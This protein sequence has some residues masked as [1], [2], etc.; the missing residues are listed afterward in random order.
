MYKLLVSLLV[1]S[2][3]LFAQSIESYVYGKNQ[4][5]YFT[6][7][8]GWVADNQAG[9]DFDFP[10]VLYPKDSSWDNATTVI[11][12]TSILK[13]KHAKKPS[14]IVRNVLKRF[15]TEL[16][17]PN[18][19]AVKVSSVN[20]NSGISAPIYKYTGDRNGNTEYVSYF[21]ADKTVNIFVMTSQD[22]NDIENSK[23]AF[24]VLNKSYREAKDC[25]P[26]N[27]KKQSCSKK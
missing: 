2:T 27:Q 19:K 20:S 11:Y 15:H 18:T 9:K 17:S 22:E 10:I 7:P 8:P 16:Q 26:C 23:P 5:Y 6:A 3:P 21:E 24:I 14:D 12:T 1:I 13:T 25:V 4:C